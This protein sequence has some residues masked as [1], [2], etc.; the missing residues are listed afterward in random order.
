MWRN[1]FSFP[2]PVNEVSARLVAGGVVVMAAVTLITDARWL[3][4]VIAYGFLARVATGPT[5]SPLGQLV[6]RVVTPLL[7]IAAKPVPGPPKRFAQGMGAVI[8]TT[9]A[10]L[11]AGL[12]LATAGKIFIGLVLVAATLESVF[13]FCIGCVVFA[14]L[15]RANLIP[16][17]VCEQ[18]NDITLRQARAAS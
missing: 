4:V 15:M 7:P 13:A 3:T 2:N 8:T 18:C 6:T 10:V 9:A 1:L 17:S 12:G 11:W 5:L 16:A 14:G